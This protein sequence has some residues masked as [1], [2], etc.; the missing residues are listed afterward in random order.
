MDDSINPPSDEPGSHED[1][2]S[3]LSDI[4]LP[5]LTAPNHPFEAT[6]IQDHAYLDAQ[7]YSASVHA[8]GLSVRIDNIVRGFEIRGPLNK[9]ILSRAIN[10]VVRKHPLLTVQFHRR[11]DKLYVQTNPG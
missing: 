1:K 11:K 10:A 5:S 2:I 9:E 7:R 4:T 8:S 6:I 3:M